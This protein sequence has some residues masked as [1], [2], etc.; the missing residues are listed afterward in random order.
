MQLDK[1]Q[2]KLSKQ[3]IVNL[4]SKLVLDSNPYPLSTG[5]S[6]PLKFYIDLESRFGIPVARGMDSKAATFCNYFGVE[7]SEECDSAA[8]PS[9]GGGTVTKVGLLQI[10]KAVKIAI[11]SERNI[12]S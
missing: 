4:I 11:D 8:S 2:L 10:L 3:E 7:W 5:S 6:I 1:S 9:G 12:L